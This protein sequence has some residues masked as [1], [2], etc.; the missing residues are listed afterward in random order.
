[1]GCPPVLNMMQRTGKPGETKEGPVQ[2][3]NH[4][5]RNVHALVDTQESSQR[6]E[7]EGSSRAVEQRKDEGR[8]NKIK[9][10]TS[11]NKSAWQQYEED[12]EAVLEATLAGSVDKKMKAMTTIMYSMGADRFGVEDHKK[13]KKGAHTNRRKQEITN[14]RGDLRRLT[15]R[16]REA[17]EGEKSV[18]WKS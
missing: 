4:S 1:M 18:R 3:S 13:D 14:I 10:P 11:N 17:E 12:V 5:D 8:R 15:K 6:E 2:E 7:P 9:W 16:F